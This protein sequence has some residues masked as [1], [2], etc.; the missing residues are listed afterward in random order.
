MMV[1]SKRWLELIVLDAQTTASWDQ[2]GG[3]DTPA[4]TSAAWF[5]GFG[6]KYLM[7]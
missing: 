5:G 4:C 6:W 1:T 7:L 3:Y 2:V